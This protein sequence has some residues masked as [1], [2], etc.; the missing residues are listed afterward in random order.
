MGSEFRRDEAER[1][2]RL[3]DSFCNVAMTDKGWTILKWGAA[4]AVVLVVVAVPLRPGRTVRVTRERLAAART[5]WDAA[6]IIDYE[7]D[8][9]VSGAQTGRYHVEVRGG[10][11]E[12]LTNNDQ[13]TDSHAPEYFTVDGLFQTIEESLSHCEHPQSGAFPEGTQIWLRMRTHPTLGYPVKFVKQI[14][15][16]G[17][18]GTTGYEE[19]SSARGV[20]VHV[21]RLQPIPAP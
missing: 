4:A 20:E 16:G 9:D 12:R 10:K 18:R 6:K 14:K 21:T 3:G 1:L 2:A 5:L 13:P 17:S 19:S 7:L 8:W 15:L 11:V